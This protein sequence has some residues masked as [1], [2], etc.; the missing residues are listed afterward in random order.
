MGKLI[1]LTLSLFEIPFII[2]SWIDYFWHLICKNLTNLLF[3]FVYLPILTIPI[4]FVNGFILS[5]IVYLKHNFIGQRITFDQA[6]QM[7][8]SRFPDL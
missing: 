7:N 5:S 8:L 3:V 6:V 1:F 2:I 4:T